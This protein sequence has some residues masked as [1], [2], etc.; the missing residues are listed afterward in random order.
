MDY[1]STTAKV[2]SKYT[3]LL[4]K[5]IYKDKILARNK[6]NIF[7][8]DK[9]KN[10]DYR[11]STILA[12]NVSKII[13]IAEETDLEIE[14]TPKGKLIELVFE[15]EKSKKRFEIDEQQL[16]YL[17]RNLEKF[18]KVLEEVEGN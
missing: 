2:S 17:I 15:S 4:Y 1:L 16:N 6:A 13:E 8:F 9:A 7:T 10:L 5:K 18:N 11:L 3:K 12:S 14:C